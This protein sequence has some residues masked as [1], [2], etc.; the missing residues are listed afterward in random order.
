MA[1]IQR[2]APGSDDSPQS[3]RA[4]DS[5]PVHSSTCTTE[6]QSGIARGKHIC[7]HLHHIYFMFVLSQTDCRC[8]MT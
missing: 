4:A 6:G 7:S 1:T 2:Q 3:T 8:M 5:T